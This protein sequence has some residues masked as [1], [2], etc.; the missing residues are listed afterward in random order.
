M[1]DAIQ[2]RENLNE[3]KKAAKRALF[4]ADKDKQ[5]VMPTN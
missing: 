4:K 1:T 3:I 5:G 2:Q